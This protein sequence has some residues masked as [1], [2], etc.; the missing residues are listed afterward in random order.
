M[1]ICVL[2]SGSSGNSTYLESKDTSVLIDAGISS[3]RIVDSLEK[4]GRDISEIDGVFISHEHIDHINGLQRLC[5]KYNVPVYMNKSTFDNSGLNIDPTFFNKE[6][7]LNELNIKPIPVSHDAA[8]PCGFRIQSNGTVLGIFT[9]LGMV[10][11]SIKQVTKEA[12]CMFIE[13]NHDIDMLINGRYPYHLKERILSQKGHLSNVDAGLLIKE[14]SCDKLKT[15]FLAHLS[16]NNNTEKLA[17]ETFSVLTKKKP[18]I[19][20]N[21]TNLVKI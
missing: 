2:A 13:S 15:V 8:D 3:K 6:V 10:N 20:K 17:F 12:D 19:A 16:K 9:D 7:K 21:T 1:K 4:I 11:D 14:N 18:L 5:D